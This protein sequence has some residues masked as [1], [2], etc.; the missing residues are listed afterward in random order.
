MSKTIE[1]NDKKFYIIKD[2]IELPKIKKRGITAWKVRETIKKEVIEKE[3]LFFYTVRGKNFYYVT[4]QGV[5]DA[6]SRI[7]YP[8]RRHKEV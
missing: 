5:L 8:K 3:E 2:V 4:Q 1:V 6:V 7:G